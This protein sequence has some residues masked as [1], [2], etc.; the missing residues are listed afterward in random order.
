MAKFKI[1]DRVRAV[2]EYDDNENIVGKIGTV[3]SVYNDTDFI[4]VEFDDEIGFCGH[5]CGGR[6]K[7]KR[8]WW[9]PDR[10]LEPVRYNEKIV[11][12]TD[13]KT[14]TAKIY[15]GKS[16]IKTT[17]AKC[18]PDDKFDFVTG[19]KIAFDRLTCRPDYEFFDWDAFKREE[20]I[21]KVTK[22]NWREF[23]SE[24]KK[25]DLT[26]CDGAVENPFEMFFDKFMRRTIPHS[27]IEVKPDEI[28][29]LYESKNLKY[30][31][32]SEGRT[33]IKW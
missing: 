5:T 21:V 30:S 26:F 6:G 27:V 9:Y 19:A 22:N 13:G 1:G 14:T 23:V 16:I 8:C 2:N 29:I 18:S 7:Y 25:H 11:I 28:F 20:T 10:I 3:I 15:A 12:T 32:I 24:A 17:T 31:H 4:G 33:V